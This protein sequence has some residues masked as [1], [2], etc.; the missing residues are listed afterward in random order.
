MKTKHSIFLLA[1]GA[2]LGVASVQSQTVISDNYNVTVV[3]S[4]FALTNGVNTGIN[5]PTT[6]ITGTAAANLRYMYVTGQL[7][8][9]NR[10][11][12]SSSRLRCLTDSANTGRFTISANGATPFDFGPYV[13]STYATPANPAVYD[14]K[15]SMRNDATSTA[16]F[17]FALTTVEGDANTWDFGLQMYRTSGAD[18]YTIQK[19]FDNASTGTA[20]D[21][22]S[23]MITMQPGT[24]TAAGNGTLQAFLIRVT[25][26]GA[27][28]STYNSR[29]QVSTNNGTSWQYDTQTN[30][31]ELTSGFRF[32]GPARILDFDQ[33]ANGSGTVWYDSLS[34]TSISSPA[35]PTPVVWTG[36]GS[37]SIWS[38]SENWGGVTPQAGQPLVFDGVLQQVNTNDVTGLDAPYLTF[39]N[40][41]FSLTGNVFTVSSTISNRAG[42]NTIGTPLAFTTTGP[43]NWVLASGSVLTLA[44]TTTVETNGDH[45]ISG[46]GTL[47]CVGPVNIGQA[48]TSNPAFSVLEGIHTIDGA[49]FSTRGGYRIGSQPTGAGGQTFLAN[50]AS[51]TITATSGNLRVGDSANS[52]TALLSMDNSTLTLNGSMIFAVGYA[53]GATAA[54]KQNGG[55]VSVPVTSF[56]EIGAGTGAYAITNGTLTTRVIRK[57]TAGGTASIYFNN[58]VLTTAAGA[59]NAFFTGLNLAQI[60]SGGLTVD[61]ESDI[62]IGQLL[63]G[64]GGIT[65]SGPST[66]TLTNANTYSGTLAINSGAVSVGAATALPS[67]STVN[68]NGGTL[69]LASN[70]TVAALQYAG[71]IKAAGTYGTIGSGATHENAQFTGT[72]ILTVTGGGTATTTVTS[73]VQAAT[74]GQNVTFTITVTGTGDG[75]VP[76]GSITLF[77]GA[78][79]LGTFALTPT[80]GTSAA[81]TYSTSSLSLGAHSMTATWAGNESYGASSS[82]NY[83]ETI[84][85]APVIVSP[86]T[87]STV[88][89]DAGTNVTL[90]IVLQ[91]T[92]GVSYQWSKGG[93]NLANGSHNNA[94]TVIGST[95]ATLTLAGV[96]AADASPGDYSCLASNA[97]GTVTSAAVTLVVNDPSISAQPTNTVIECGSNG[98]LS[99]TAIGTTN[100][101]GVLLYQWYTPNAAGTAIADAT[102]STLCFNNVHANQGSYVV[103]VSNAFG[104]S[105]TSQVAV[106]TVHDTTAPVV[107]LNGAANV[108]VECHGSFSD[109]GAS[110]SDVCDGNSSISAPTSG[111]ANLN[112]VGDYTVTYT[113]SDSS[114]NPGNSVTR[115]VHVRDGTVPNVAL[116]GASSINI[117]CHGSYADP[118]ASATDICDTNPGVTTNGNVNVDARGSYTVTYTATDASGN[119][120]ST[121]R[122]FVVVDT[123]PPVVT[124]NS[125]A[126]VTV[127]CHGS[128]SDPGATA[129][130]ACDPAP[131]MS[132]SGSVLTNVPGTYT[133]TYTATDAV[134]NHGSATL[135]V[136][137][138][139]TIPPVVTL[140]GEAS[141]TVECHGT[142]TDPGATAL[143]VCD[144]S[145]SMNT[146]SPVNV[147]AP[148]TYTVTYTATDAGGHHGSSTREVVVADTLAP[149]VT[150]NSGDNTVCVNGSYND[151]G[152]TGSDV[153]QGS[154]SATPSAT[155]DTSVA[156]NFTLTYI[157]TDS[158]LNSGSATRVV[159]VVACAATITGQPHSQTV[160][161]SGTLNLSVV[162]SGSGLTYQWKLGGIAILDATNA[163]Y[164]KTNVTTADAGSYT[165]D[166]TLGSTVTS[167]PAIV[168]I[169]DPGISVQPVSVIA[170]TA[171]PAT[172]SITAG[173]TGVLKYQWYFIKGGTAVA[174]ALAKMTNASLTLPKVA[175][176]GNGGIYY[177]TV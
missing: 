28:S 53:A 130:D 4:G 119:H 43:K 81:A 40:G 163:T 62:T 175:S 166:V 93:V 22:N 44:N 38:A 12:I 135:Q 151:P 103:V 8:A 61:A 26:A 16:R 21:I 30:T 110:V 14:I 7:R 60:Q 133:V 134:G 177:C 33:A 9:T 42:A 79:N 54:V 157:A 69:D 123:T 128:F 67:A 105:I 57:N 20:A 68:L 138:S 149:V 98:C 154:I 111:S 137:V 70:P 168:T 80:T 115:V 51:L 162:A 96:K 82:A 77:D 121:T 83:T 19:R 58:A 127:E 144:A 25:D 118:G 6:R 31:T 84:V 37:S 142:F 131:S 48:T 65:K 139:D 52:H 94:A 18:F 50:N 41:G 150:L 165:V 145:P 104:N 90:T 95:A 71:V 143:D 148:G 171:T 101:D 120:S 39:D 46:G 97:A 159:Q 49:A 174:K 2:L 164:M 86:T 152:A 78:S 136:V 129:L 102:N 74:V 132:T 114:N 24:T 173:G 13:G 47:R 63:S 176:A 72:G 75:T 125:G 36:A 169:N 117:E 141:V 140:N 88:V 55:T 76:N 1:I 126:T 160:P 99:V 108:T 156:G 23:P 116:I 59:S 15:I 89:A 153:C 170:T 64:T 91:D 147:N 87:A 17:S 167:D 113:A 158:S 45:T 172:F 106:V 32:D 5:P 124:R 85:Q 161:A 35:P 27:E 11:D 29:I 73:D 107:T 3:N 109:P 10:Y 112:A 100:A 122:E 92:F 146:N 66:L 155:V 34:I 56:S